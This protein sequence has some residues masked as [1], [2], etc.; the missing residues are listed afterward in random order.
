MSECGLLWPFDPASAGV[1]SKPAAGW[2]AGSAAAG[3]TVPATANAPTFNQT[4]GLKNKFASRVLVGSG[5]RKK[6]IQNAGDAD[7][8]QADMPNLNSSFLSVT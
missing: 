6:D 1:P 8:N 7:D 2:A 3:A 4:F 5:A